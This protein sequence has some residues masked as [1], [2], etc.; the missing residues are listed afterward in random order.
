MVRDRLS[1]DAWEQI[2]EAFPP[3]AAVGRKRK[4][5]RDMVDGILY[6]LRTGCP[7]RDLPEEFGPLACPLQTSP[8]SDRRSGR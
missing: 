3:P 6:V 7:W 1:E 4:D 8:C 2:A 5:P